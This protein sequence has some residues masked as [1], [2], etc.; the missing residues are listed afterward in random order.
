MMKLS[1]KTIDSLVSGVDWTAG[2]N[3]VMDLSNVLT[4]LGI[5]ARLSDV[6]EALRYAKR[7][8]DHDG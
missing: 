2:V 6:F 4:K 5:T 8:E 1:K 7:L 3:E